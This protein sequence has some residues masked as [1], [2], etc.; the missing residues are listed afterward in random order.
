MTSI[1]IDNKAAKNLNRLSENPVASW[2]LKLLKQRQNDHAQRYCE[3]AIKVKGS[4][5]LFVRYP[6]LS[7]FMTKWFNYFNL[8]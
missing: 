7:A 8:F 6:L 2:S 3:N 5:E 1:K 4:V